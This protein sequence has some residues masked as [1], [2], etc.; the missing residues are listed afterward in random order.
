MDDFSTE[1]VTITISLT[2]IRAIEYRSTGCVQWCAIFNFRHHQSTMENGE[3][4]YSKR[5]QKLNLICSKSFCSQEHHRPRFLMR[6]MHKKV[7]SRYMQEAQ[8]RRIKSTF[9]NVASKELSKVECI[10]VMGWFIFRDRVLEPSAAWE[11]MF[12][13]FLFISCP[14]SLLEVTRKY[15]KWKSVQRLFY[16]WPS[17]AEVGY[18]MEER[19]I[20]L[21]ILKGCPWV[22]VKYQK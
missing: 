2:R 3:S 16:S 9:Y 6:T 20:A 1:H 7:T 11:M 8:N 17:E 18:G 4:Q 15:R 19:E 14:R 13:F 10:S 12:I 22:L 5:G 21:D